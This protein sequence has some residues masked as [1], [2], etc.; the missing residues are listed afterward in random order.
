MH[1]STIREVFRPGGTASTA[2]RAGSGRSRALDVPRL[3]LV[4]TPGTGK[5][6]VGAHLAEERGFA[7][8]DFEHEE[9]RDSLLDAN[10]A[11]L[12]HRLAAIAEGRGIVITWGAGS[13]AQLDELERLARLGFELIWFD[14]DRGAAV[15]AHYGESRLPRFRFVDSFELDGRFRPVEAVVRE[16]LDAPARLRTR[17][18][19]S[20]PVARVAQLSLRV[21]GGLALAAGTAFATVLALSGGSPA[22]RPAAAPAVAVSHLA[23][24]PHRGVLVSGHSLAGVHLGDTTATVRA[25]WGAHF[26]PCPGYGRAMWCY[27]YPPPADPVGAGVQF[28]GGKVVAVFTLGSPLGW[29]TSAGI[30]IGQTLVNPNAG[31]VAGTKWLSCSG[32]SAKATPTGANAVTSILTQGASVY[33]FALTRPSVSPCM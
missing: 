27:L 16:V 15:G 32:Y 31:F 3:L 2:R 22:A 5:R 28:A 23:A 26:T 7:H 29:H 14:G 24:L 20:L 11:D 12:R 6:P 10:E 13:P 8:L 33:G 4:G 25:L 9:V 19:R 21:A 17:A 18:V 30:R 1:R